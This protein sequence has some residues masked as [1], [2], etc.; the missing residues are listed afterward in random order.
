MLRPTGP[1]HGFVTIV[2]VGCF[3]YVMKKVFDIY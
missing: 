1:L 3:L 2:K